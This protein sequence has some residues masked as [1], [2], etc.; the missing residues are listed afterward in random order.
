MSILH[1]GSGRKGNVSSNMQPSGKD[2][3]MVGDAL[4]QQRRVKL[5]GTVSNVFRS[6]KKKKKKKEPHF[7]AEMNMG[8]IL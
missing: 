1:R 8:D 5:P 6:K 7:T 2:L 3:Y 4:G